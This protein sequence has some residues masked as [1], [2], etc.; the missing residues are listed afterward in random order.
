MNTLTTSRSAYQSFMT[1]PRLYFI[2]YQYSPDDASIGQGIVP[3]LV[4]P[5]LALGTFVHEVC[6]AVMGGGSEEENIKKQSDIWNELAQSRGFDS[7]F[8]P[9]LLLALAQGLSKTWIRS[10]LPQ[11]EKGTLYSR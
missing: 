11:I 5:D 6:G 9:D 7:L 4:S 10:R 3:K 2:T 1:S 8:N